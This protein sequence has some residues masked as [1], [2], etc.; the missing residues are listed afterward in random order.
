MILTTEHFVGTS[1][2]TALET[3]VEDA[4]F[5]EEYRILFNKRYTKE[6]KT[7]FQEAREDLK[8]PIITHLYVASAEDGETVVDLSL[9]PPDALR[10]S[11]LT[12]QAHQT[13]QVLMKGKG[14]YTQ[15]RAAEL[16]TDLVDLTQCNVTEYCRAKLSS[17]TK[18]ASDDSRPKDLEESL[19]EVVLLI[20]PTM[21]LPGEKIVKTIRAKPGQFPCSCIAT[22]ILRP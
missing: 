2:C 14:E 1:K 15:R 6:T 13:A 9:S 19:L 16:V 17:P 8:V 12:P 21:E 7:K 20:E 11:R 4:T 5:F 10:L 22:M 3:A 18:R